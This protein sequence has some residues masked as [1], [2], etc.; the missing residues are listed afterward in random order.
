MT[1]WILRKLS[2]QPLSMVE[3][4]IQEARQLGKIEAISKFVSIHAIS[5]DEDTFAEIP[6][7][8]YAQLKAVI[9]TFKSKTRLELTAPVNT[10]IHINEIKIQDAKEE[11]SN[12]EEQFD[13]IDHIAQR[14]IEIQHM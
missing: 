10:P 7:E 3:E 12:L 2:Q 13:I 1:E 5:D 4:S 11:Q 14:L 8:L 9:T 6:N